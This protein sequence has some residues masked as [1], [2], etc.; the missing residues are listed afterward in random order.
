MFDVRKDDTSKTVYN[1]RRAS[2]LLCCLSWPCSR[3]KGSQNHTHGEGY[4]IPESADRGSKL[5]TLR[6]Y[7]HHTSSFDYDSSGGWSADSIRLAYPNS[8][9]VWSRWF[10]RSSK[11]NQSMAAC[12]VASSVDH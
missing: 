7:D 1:T 6:R 8:E 4:G 11:R 12:V 3:E 10:G 2:A 5:V 9:S